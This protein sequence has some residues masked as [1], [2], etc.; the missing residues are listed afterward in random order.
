MLKPGEML[1]LPAAINIMVDKLSRIEQAVR[2]LQAQRPPE[3]PEARVDTIVLSSSGNRQRIQ[4]PTDISITG[5]FLTSETTGRNTLNF[6]SDPFPIYSQAFATLYY[7]L[8]EHNR[9][10]VR[11]TD[12][13]FTPAN[14]A[15]IWD[16]VLFWHPKRG[17][18]AGA[19]GRS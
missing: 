14:P 13:S 16:I 2:D 18:M 6:G 7:N 8:M 19:A 1:S 9:I 15:D 10:D 12:I 5:I 3:R 4:V 17:Q 11:Q